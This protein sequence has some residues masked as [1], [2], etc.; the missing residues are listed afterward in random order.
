MRRYLPRRQKQK[1]PECLRPNEGKRK[2]ALLS[3]SDTE[4]STYDAIL[5]SSRPGVR[6]N[7]LITGIVN[8][9]GTAN[10]YA[11]FLMTDR[12]DTVEPTPPT[13]ESFIILRSAGNLEVLR[14]VSFTP[15]TAKWHSIEMNEGGRVA[16]YETPAVFL[17]AR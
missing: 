8:G 7:P 5:L 17:L 4:W 9:D 16:S 3:P 1:R 6:A 13:G 2:E 11:I 12:L 15:G 10:N 14:G